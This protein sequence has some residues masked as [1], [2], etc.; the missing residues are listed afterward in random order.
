MTSPPI[1]PGRVFETVNI[2][3]PD[4]LP[5]DLPSRF[6]DLCSARLPQ[7]FPVLPPCPPARLAAAVGQAG[8]ASGI[9]A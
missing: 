9:P 6:T 7:H 2:C 8:S 5:V 3:R 1:L 4:A